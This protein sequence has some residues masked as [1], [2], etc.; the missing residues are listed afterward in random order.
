MKKPWTQLKTTDDKLEYLH[1]EI[2]SLR[3]HLSGMIFDTRLARRIDQLEARV[4]EIA[5]DLRIFREKKIG[6]RV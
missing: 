3:A 2:D 5:N 1:D 4:K 6:T